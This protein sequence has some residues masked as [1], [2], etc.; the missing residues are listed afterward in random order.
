MLTLL[1]TLLYS[2]DAVSTALSICCDYRR[3]IFISFFNVTDVRLMLCETSRNTRDDL[4]KGAC[5]A[6]LVQLHHL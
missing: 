4:L 1:C 6:L 3:I 5:I 2:S